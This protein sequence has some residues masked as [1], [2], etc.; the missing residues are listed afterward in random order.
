MKWVQ[1]GG[2][3]APGAFCAEGALAGWLKLKLVQVGVSQNDPCRGSP[4]GEAG[5]EEECELRRGRDGGP[6]VLHAGG[7]W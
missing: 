4:G 2:E 6:R 7:A 1:D 5:T 3:G